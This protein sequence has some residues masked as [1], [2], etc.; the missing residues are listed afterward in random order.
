MWRS[1]IER[2]GSAVERLALAYAL[3]AWEPHPAQRRFFAS[4]AQVRVAACGRRWGKTESLSIDVASLAVAEA[5]HGRDCRQLIVAPSDVQAR[6]LGN[7]VL[8]RLLDAFDAGTS[9]TAGLSIDVRQRP[10]L[11]ITIAPEGIGKVDNAKK[12]RGAGPAVS[13][14]IFRTAGRDGSSLRGLWAHRIIAD[15][16]SR[17]PDAVMTEVLMPM[18]M[19]VGGEYVLAS[20]P[21][22]RRSAFYR[23]FARALSAGGLADEHGLTMAAQQ[24]PTQ[25]NPHNDAA[26]LASMRDELGDSMYAQ[27]IMAE[28]SDDFGAVFRADDIDGCLETNALVESVKGELL[29]E[30]IP[31]HVYSVGIDWGRKMDYTV[32]AVLDATDP[33][34]RLVSLQRWHGTGWEA[35]ARAVAETICRFEPVRVLADGN[36]IGDPLAETLTTEIQRGHERRQTP[37]PRIVPVERFLFGPESKLRLVDHLNLSLSSRTLRYPNHKALLGELRGFEYGAVGSSGRARMAARGS[38]HDDIVM[39]LALADYC[40]PSGAPDAP[41]LLFGSSLSGGGGRGA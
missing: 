30:P 14:M 36:S 16:A 18:L 41:G 24:C 22:G 34:A 1:E 5:K 12:A 37:D 25:D 29:S 9:W 4:G 2:Q 17:I 15:E 40:A 19:D 11:Q 31:G 28:F 27:E 38:G 6:L 35:Q 10:S 8:M 23:L 39:A 33:V 21:Y 13:R 32:V 26:F 7:E 20:S 3:W